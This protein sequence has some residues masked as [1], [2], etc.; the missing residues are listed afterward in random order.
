MTGDKN[1]QFQGARCSSKLYVFM[2][3]CHIA[4]QNVALGQYNLNTVDKF[5]CD[6]KN[7]QH[8]R[9]QQLDVIGKEIKGSLENEKLCKPL[10]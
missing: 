2:V 5:L 6:I 7:V 3:F 1:W 10:I 9:V 4:M 8:H